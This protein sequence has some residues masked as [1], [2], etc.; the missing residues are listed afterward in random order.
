MTARTLLEKWKLLGA[1]M[2]DSSLPCSA[3][4]I[5]FSILDH[6]NTKT[7]RCDP[8]LVGL[9]ERTSTPKRTVIRAIQA[10]VDAGYFRVRHGGGRR[11]RNSYM[12]AWETVTP[13]TPFDDQ[14]TVTFETEK[15]DILDQETVT[16]ETPEHGNRTR[17]EHEKKTL[18]E[19]AESFERFFT[20]YP[21]RRPHSNPR[22]PAQQKFEAA[23]KHGVDPEDIIRGAKNYAR[24]VAAEGTDPKYVAQAVTW[25]NQERWTEHQEPPAPAGPAYSGAAI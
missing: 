16:P 12:P 11:R 10:L 15:G 4:V 6:L 2:A 9:A 23:V 20:T 13:E 3:K 18:G 14:E 17:E 21:S 24:Y 22:K 5:A 1:I 7:G 25:L 19:N 8:S